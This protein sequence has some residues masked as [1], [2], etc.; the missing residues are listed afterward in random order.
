MERPWLR[1]I[2]GLWWVFVQRLLIEY[3]GF[4]HS[5]LSHTCTMLCVKMCLKYCLLRMN[6]LR[7]HVN[8]FFSHHLGCLSIEKGYYTCINK[9]KEPVWILFCS[10]LKISHELFSLY[11]HTNTLYTRKHIISVG[12]TLYTKSNALH[13]QYTFNIH[14]THTKCT[15]NLKYTIIHTRFTVNTHCK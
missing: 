3:R 9:F 2:S 1:F 15:L 4:P 7:L 13:R 8:F 5:L 14:S 12:D 10:S 6:H 11:T